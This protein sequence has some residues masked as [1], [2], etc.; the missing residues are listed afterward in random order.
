MKVFFVKLLAFLD[1]CLSRRKA[2]KVV[3]FL[4][5]VNLLYI[6]GTVI[7]LNYL[8]LFTILFGRLPQ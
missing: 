6:E 4:L 2:I 5:V 8:Q 1:H 3:Q 7:S